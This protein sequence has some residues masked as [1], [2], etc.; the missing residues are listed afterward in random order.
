M[1]NVHPDS[2]LAFAYIGSCLTG[3]AKRWYSDHVVDK[4][5]KRRR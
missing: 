5:P 2:Y 1:G 3:E 4:L